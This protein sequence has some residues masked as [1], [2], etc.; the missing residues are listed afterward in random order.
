MG[1][2]ASDQDTQSNVSLP[3]T[4]KKEAL[5]DILRTY[6]EAKNKFNLD[7]KKLQRKLF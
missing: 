7:L 3:N 6:A 1:Y 4:E 2:R 5:N